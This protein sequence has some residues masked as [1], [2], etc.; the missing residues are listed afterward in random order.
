VVDVVE[1]APMSDLAQLDGGNAQSFSVG[2]RD[3]AE[4]VGSEVS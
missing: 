3:V 4:L 2:R 1:S